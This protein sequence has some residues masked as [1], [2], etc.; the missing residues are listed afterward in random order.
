MIIYDKHEETRK[1]IRAVI[2]IRFSSKQQADSYSIEYQQEECLKYIEKKGYKFVKSYIDE[3]KTGKRTAGREALEQMLFDAGRN[4]FDRIIVFSFSR[5]FR[6][7]R[8]A[9]NT[10]HELMEKHGI[11]IESVIEPIDLTSPHGKFSGT[12][13]FAMHEL[14]S[15][16]IA[17][18][19]RSGMYIAA[20][21]GYYLGG[22]VTFGYDTYD[23]GELTR[24]KARKKF[25]I[26]E[27]EAEIV[28]L[29]YKMF[30]DGF[31]I[32]YI[33]DELISQNVR[34][35]KSNN[36]ITAPNVSRLLKDKFY[37][38]TRKFDIKGYEPLLIENAVP[39]I[40]D[41]ETFDA[42][43]AKFAENKDKPKPRRRTKRFYSLT[44]K[45]VCDKC[46]GYF[47]GVAKKDPKVKDKFYL[48]Y[49]CNTKH[50]LR[51]CDA[52]N[53]RKEFLEEYCIKQIKKHILTPEKIKE[54]AAFIVSQTDGTPELIQEEFT[55]AE[56]RKRKVLE[57]IKKMKRDMYEMDDAEAEAQ[58]ELIAE[59]SKELNEL[60]EK[61]ARLESIETTVIS[62]KMVVEFLEECALN[63]DSP[64]PHILKT[65]FEKL[66][67]KIVIT[68]DKVE[69]TLIVFPYA[70]TARKELCGSPH[71]AL[72][73]IINRDE[74]DQHASYR[75]N[76]KAGD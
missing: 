71:Y 18:H 62:E 20:K 50:N 42:V 16:I 59:Y 48:N 40:I 22:N 60:N 64:D 7:T 76:K 57:I 51:T 36:L 58:Q 3:A 27:E 8:D 31:S 5:S 63:I 38:G 52:K 1:I 56:K 19:V 30:L 41:K 25:C 15:D 10:N 35:R 21:Q 49:V 54:I 72:S 2:Y 65:V 39:A 61:L 13:L 46:G 26:N 14:Q 67:E 32:N 34:M 66:I 9:L 6:N 55:H 11:A 74:Y 4:K 28:R 33:R 12:N 70:N 47:Y 37:I 44:G 43:Q 24:G 23:T 69:L 73:A 17:A 75:K 45:I 29:M 68:D 53:I